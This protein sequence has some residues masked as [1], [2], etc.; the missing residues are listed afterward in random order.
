MSMKI[1]I[2]LFLLMVTMGLSVAEKDKITYTKDDNGQ[3]IRLEISNGEDNL[4]YSFYP[5]GS[6]QYIIRERNDIRRFSYY[7]GSEVQVVTTQKNEIQC[8]AH[9]FY[10]HSGQLIEEI[11]Y[12]P[13]DKAI[14]KE[15]RSGFWTQYD[16]LGNVLLQIEYENN[17]VKDTIVNLNNGNK[18]IVDN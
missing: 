2:V 9:Y 15:I 6:T 11:N 8:G 10:N 16:S 3:L 12:S 7:Y 14:T 18:F 17:L 4:Q 13:C 5:N 1:Y